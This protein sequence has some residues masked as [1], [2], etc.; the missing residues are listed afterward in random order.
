LILGVIEPLE[1]SGKLLKLALSSGPKALWKLSWFLKDF[2][3]SSSLIYEDQIDVLELVGCE[4]VI[5]ISYQEFSG[6]PQL[7]IDAFA[8]AHSW[9]RVGPR[10]RAGAA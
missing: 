5:C 7:T 6:Y 8:P 2:E 4:G 3:Y 1:Y 9:D 10:S